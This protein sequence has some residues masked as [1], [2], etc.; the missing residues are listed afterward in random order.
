MGRGNNQPL[1][2][3]K[4]NRDRDKETEG[5]G[6]VCGNVN[7]KLQG[8]TNI[9]KSGALKSTFVDLL[10]KEKLINSFQQ[11]SPYSLTDSHTLDFTSLGP[12]KCFLFFC[13]FLQMVNLIC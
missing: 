6:M 1:V 3:M 2:M 9:W 8:N 5:M 11:R 13:F 12:K 10:G 7:K 4:D